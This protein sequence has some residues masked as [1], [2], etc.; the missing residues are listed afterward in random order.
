MI[1]L[2]VLGG[3]ILASNIEKYISSAEKSTNI[4]IKYQNKDIEK[5]NELR[6]II[7]TVLCKYLDGEGFINHLDESFFS[8]NED[9]KKIKHFNITVSIIKKR[10]N[11]LNKSKIKLLIKLSDE[12]NIKDININN[13]NE[14]INNILNIIKEY[15]AFRIRENHNTSLDDI[16][17]IFREY[18]FRL[19]IKRPTNLNIDFK[20]FSYYLLSDKYYTNNKPEKV[21]LTNEQV[22]EI[23]SRIVKIDNIKNKI[24]DIDYNIHRC[25]LI[26]SVWSFCMYFKDMFKEMSSFISEEYL[27]CFIK[28]YNTPFIYFYNENKDKNYYCN[29]D[30]IRDKLC[31]EYIDKMIVLILDNNYFSNKLINFMEMG[32]ENY[33]SINDI[34]NYNSEMSYFL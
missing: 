27:E 24:S 1:D 32:S 13:L 15:K 16:Y 18:D 31:R 10:I 25:V 4:D 14:I 22:I 11:I 29:L 33:K 34:Y 23:I 30:I 9:K 19:G 2:L 17:N 7:N 26:P 21:N 3:I 5:I 12:Q 6:N 8:D 20:E 28:I